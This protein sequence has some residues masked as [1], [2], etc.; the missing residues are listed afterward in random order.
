MGGFA[1]R[2][3]FKDFIWINCLNS[4]YQQNY[5]AKL[6]GKHKFI[7]LVAKYM[8]DRIQLK[9]NVLHRHSSGIYGT[10]AGFFYPCC[11]DTCSRSSF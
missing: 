1:T 7:S 9:Q 10:L 5:K 2:P 6:Q 4:T 11:A 8:G 3:T